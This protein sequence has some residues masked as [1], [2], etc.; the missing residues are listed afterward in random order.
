M[1]MLA[2]GAGWRT[3]LVLI[4]FVVSSSLC[5][6]DQALLQM[7]DV[8]RIMK[9]ILEQHAEQKEMSASILRKSFKVYIDQFDPNR[10]YLL[11][12]EVKPYFN[13]TDEQVQNI[14]ANYKKGN[15]SQY[16]KTQ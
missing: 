8:S 16:E 5:H 13:L 7:D 6:A 14:L 3:W 15:F 1:L 2:L 9:Q 11:D 12:E 4:A 10:M